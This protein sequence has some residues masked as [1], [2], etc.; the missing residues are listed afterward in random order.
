[1]TAAELA[2]VFQEAGHHHHQ[3]YIDADGADPEWALWYAGFLQ[4]HIWDRLGRIPTRSELVYLLIGC[5]L[6]YQ[7]GGDDRRWPEVYADEFIAHFG[8]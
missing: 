1:M 5:D 3:A 8:A 6:A 2:D 7:A 4:T